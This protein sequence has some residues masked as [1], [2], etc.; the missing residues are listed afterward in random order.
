MQILTFLGVPSTYMVAFCTL[1]NQRVF[2]RRLEWLTLLP[3]I[4]AFKH[5]SHLAMALPLTVF[6]GLS[7]IDRDGRKSLVQHVETPSGDVPGCLC[8]CR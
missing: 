8:R 6:E 2:V 3:D 5:T 4:P 1:E 7:R